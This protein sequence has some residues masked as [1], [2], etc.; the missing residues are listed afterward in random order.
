[1]QLLK[2]NQLGINPA[3]V[4]LI[5][6]DTDLKGLGLS[7]NQLDYLNDT[8]GKIN[9]PGALRLCILNEFPKWMVFV[10]PDQKKLGDDLR[11]S[12]RLDGT[13]IQKWANSQKLEE[14]ELIDLSNNT[15][16]LQCTVEGLVLSN[17]QFLPYF[18]DVEKKKNSLSKIGIDLNDEK[19]LAKLRVLIEAVF[20]TRDLVNEPLSSL[21]AP[22][23][24]DEIETM[25]RKVGIDVEIM[26]KAKIEALKFGGLLAVNKG[27]IDPPRFCVLEY[28]PEKAVN[29]K[30]LVLVGKGIVYDTGGLSL[31]PTGNSMDYMKSDM[32]GA[33]AVVGAIY[34][35]A[36]LNL[37]VHVITLVPATD[38][39]P[40]G[41]AYVPG[42]II[43]MHSGLFVEVLNTDAEGRMILADAL[44]YAKKYD[45]DLVIDLATL[46]GAAAVAVGTIGTVIMGSAGSAV[47]EDIKA[48]GNSCYERTVEFPLWEE[49]AK[50]L[51]SEVADIKNIG[52]RD[53]GAITAGKFLERFTDY[54]WV[55][56]DIAGP[57]F[58]FSPDGY[59]TTGGT[60]TGVRLLI[61]FIEKHY[62]KN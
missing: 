16:R 60:G 56:M 9:K 47:L 2:R 53:A 40:D 36:A 62:L 6:N 51:E 57:S 35:V 5:N 11:E 14:I 27:S 59:R 8:V 4:Y 49:Y 21:N 45:P 46:T 12:Y 31:K 48:A 37:P 23:L 52:G 32:A 61:E 17:Y 33:A 41:N 44:S 13:Q 30:P 18:S 42:D 54:P 28:K 25:A 26:D 50:L 24:A 10:L 34:A 1:M 15:D 58:I 39:R 3:T 55:H 43:R 22:K 29:D 20:R 19:A 38:N 7:N